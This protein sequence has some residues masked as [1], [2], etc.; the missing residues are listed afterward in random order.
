M[1]ISSSQI[2]AIHPGQHVKETV[3]P[4]DLSVTKAAE[5]LGVGRPALSNLLNGNAALTPEMAMRIEKAF[6]AKAQDLLT[7]QAAYDEFQGREQAKEMAV[8]T[9]VRAFLGIEARQI[10]AWALGNI[11]A[12]AEL[13]VLLRRL[14]HSTGTSLTKVD[15]PAHDNS[16]RH[17]WDGFI[18]SDEATPWIPRGNSGWEFGSDQKPERKAE[19]D[20]AARMAS[21]SADERSATT[22][23]FVSPHNWPGKE[24][25]AKEKRATGAWKDVCAYD[26][27]DLEQWLEQ[28]VATQAWFCEKLGNGAEGTASPEKCWAEWANASEP[29]LSKILFRAAVAS[30]KSKLETW[31][32]QPPRT[33]FIVT[34]DSEGEALAFVACALEAFGKFPGEFNAR[35]LVLRTVDALKRTTVSA[36][37]FVAIISSPEVE[38]ASAGLQTTHHILI[39]RR[40]NDMSGEP[41]IALDLV[42]DITYREALTAMGLHEPDYHRYARE[43]ANSPTI[44]R[45]HLSKVPAIHNPAWSSDKAL[46]RSLIPRNFAGV[47][48]S[49]TLRIERSSV[50]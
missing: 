17:G 41:D 20:F 33:P 14:V 38:A 45:R 32:A 5:L 46:A 24:S 16:Q 44:L 39:A 13:P 34:A 35:A 26:A 7:L 49:K 21:I 50:V 15:F 8:R 48:D 29:P 19:S 1:T 12:R 36:P 11:E 30:A 42:D 23:V 22:F 3:L 37:D 28:S 9:Y 25:W 10:S 40:R 43:T 4:K 18:S 6:G 27:S 47:W 2:S 31:L